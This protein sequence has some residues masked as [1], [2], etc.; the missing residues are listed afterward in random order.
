VQCSGNIYLNYFL[1]LPWTHPGG[2]PPFYIERLECSIKH[3]CTEEK[4]S[5]PT[6]WNVVG[7]E[8]TSR[9][10]VTENSTAVLIRYFIIQRCANS[11]NLRSVNLEKKFGTFRI[12]SRNLQLKKPKKPDQTKPRTFG[13]WF[14]NKSQ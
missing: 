7:A 13:I 1:N 3:H 14:R 2:F 8:R 10:N 4:S 5:T 11:K 12:E 9:H 6:V